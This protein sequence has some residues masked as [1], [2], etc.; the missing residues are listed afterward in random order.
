MLIDANRVESLIGR[1]TVAIVA[2]HL[3]GMAADSDAL[4]A[5]AAR[6]GLRL[7][8]GRVPR[9]TERDFAVAPWDRLPMPRP[10]ACTRLRISARLATRAWWCP[11][12]SSCSIALGCS[13]TMVSASVTA[14]RCGR[15]RLDELQAALLRIKLVHLDRW[16]ALRRAR[17]EQYLGELS[18]Y[19][20]LALPAVVDG[21]R[22]RSGINSLFPLRSRARP[23]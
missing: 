8:E 6:H 18:G 7:L 11:T 10:S 2:V 13:R 3:Y 5:I 9:L 23:R 14:A 16:N 1:R 19:P 20:E 22:R 21:A 17:A 4:S 12:T 15:S